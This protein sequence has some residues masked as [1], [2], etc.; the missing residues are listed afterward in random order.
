MEYKVIN[1]ENLK[2]EVVEINESKA[3]AILFFDNNILVAKYGG[4]YLFPGGKIDT[5]E[6][7]YSA[8]IRELEEETGI[9]YDS[10]ELEPLLLLDFYQ[11]NYPTRNGNVKNRR[12]KTYY[13]SGAY[14]GIDLSK[15]KRTEKEKKDNFSL[16]LINIE[17]LYKKIEFLSDN[18]RNIYFNTEIK[19]VLDYLNHSYSKL[20]MK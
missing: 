6:D 13:F 5:F 20:K 19:E 10:I 16:E 3:R 8:I 17:D 15:I 1:E 11:K 18:P 7:E 9:V 4:L 14:K 2:D 12:I